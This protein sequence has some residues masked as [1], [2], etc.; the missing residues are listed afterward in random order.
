MI[1]PSAR[2][3]PTTASTYV[4]DVHATITSPPLPLKNSRL[5]LFPIQGRLYL[6]HG[7]WTANLGPTN[8]ISI[9]T[10]G[11]VTVDLPDVMSDAFNC[12]REIDGAIYAPYTD[13]RGA[14]KGGFAT[15]VGGE[16]HAVEF[17]STLMVHCFDMGATSH[18]LWMTGSAHREESTTIPVVLLST[19]GGATWTE[20]QSGE[21][22]SVARY[23][24]LWVEGDSVFV[25]QGS[26]PVLTSSDGGQTWSEIDRPDLHLALSSSGYR[27]PHYVRTPDPTPYEQVLRD[28]APVMPAASSDFVVLDGVAYC[29]AQTGSLVT[30][31]SRPAPS[32]A[33]S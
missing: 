8:V 31:H 33:E 12:F 21:R 25:R 2:R 9:G 15:N 4:W 3:F 13:P 14:D 10:E 28:W 7:E 23:Y 19:D 5:S 1:I 6:G 29:A 16:W 18:G 20:V 17:T 24:G 22:G 11:D 32:G 26:G 27:R 30:I